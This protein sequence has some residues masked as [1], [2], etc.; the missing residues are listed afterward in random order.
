MRL[1]DTKNFKYPRN[2]YSKVD[3]FLILNQS[4]SAK[5]QDLANGQLLILP[6][7]TLNIFLKIMP[8]KIYR[9]YSAATYIW[10]YFFPLTIEPRH[11]KTCIPGLRP[12]K[13]QTGLL[14]YRD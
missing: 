9:Y 2:E 8:A 12:V 6:R 1:T 7:N 14:S 11:E 13:T 4:I 10:D 5:N 3:L